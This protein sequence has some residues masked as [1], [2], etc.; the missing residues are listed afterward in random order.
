MSSA[1]Q[2]QFVG[3]SAADALMLA[4]LREM[5][6]PRYLH[7]TVVQPAGAERVAFDDL[8]AAL[9]GR[10]PRAGD[11]WR[12]HFHVPIF[13]ERIGPLDP[14]QSDIDACLRSLPPGDMP[15][16]EVETYAWEVLP[17][18]LRPADLADGIARELLWLESRLSAVRP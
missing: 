4:A 18:A 3:G 12:V 10:V 9:A 1:P 13:L 6:E 7:Q 14:T 17:P 5:A 16:I 11:V 15:C 8:D 2:A